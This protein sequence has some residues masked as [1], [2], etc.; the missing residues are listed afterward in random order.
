MALEPSGER[1][2]VWH[3]ARAVALGTTI[4]FFVG[5]LLATVFGLTTLALLSGG[6]AGGVAGSR[7]MR[8]GPTDRVAIA[9]Y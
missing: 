3:Y 5:F 1:R 9:G 8:G 2:T 7:A 4:G 6:I